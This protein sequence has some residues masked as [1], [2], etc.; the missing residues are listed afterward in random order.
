M[1]HDRVER[2]H[3][4]PLRRY[5]A[6]L[7]HPRSPVRPVVHREHRQRHIEAVVPERQVPRDSPHDR[8]AR[9]TLRNHPERRFER[10]HKAVCRLIRACSRA[11]VQHR[12]RAT[13]RIHDGSSDA[14]VRPPRTRVPRPD[15][16][17]D[18][19]HARASQTSPSAR[20]HH[21]PLSRPARLALPRPPLVAA[22]IPAVPATWLG[23]EPPV[24]EPRLKRSG[25][26]PQEPWSA[27]YNDASSPHR[28]RCRFVSKYEP[29]ASCQSL[30]RPTGSPGGP[31]RPLPARFVPMP[32][33]PSSPTDAPPPSPLPPVRA[34]L[35]SQRRP[36][37]GPWGT[38]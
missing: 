19:G 33:A 9:R 29:L 23:R 36:P 12:P 32:T 24:S 2:Q 1:A 14:H 4:D 8:T 20:Q 37:A 6:H 25:R 11:H 31:H 17:M 10:H 26:P 38:R 3:H 30:C 7:R 18:R 22:R 21:I 34:T 35:L 28:H 27:C 15:A 13:Q 5:P 16:V